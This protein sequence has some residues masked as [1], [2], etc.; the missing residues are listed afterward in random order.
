MKCS[1]GISDFLEEIS[2]LCHFIVFH[3]IVKILYMCTYNS[4]Y[5]ENVKDG[6]IVQVKYVIQ[7]YY[8]S[9]MF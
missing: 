6:I 3:L 4:E 1:L 7:R 8:E 5:E 9:E 2:S